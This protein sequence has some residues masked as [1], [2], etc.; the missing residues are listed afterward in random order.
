MRRLHISHVGGPD[1]IRKEAWSFH[2]KKSGV[3]LCWELPEP[4]GPK[5]QVHVCKSHP[6]CSLFAQDSGPVNSVPSPGEALRHAPEDTLAFEM[7]HTLA[8]EI[9][10]GFTCD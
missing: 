7:R 4:K 1:V 2:R 8:F 5:G 3:R 9:K 6:R 10:E